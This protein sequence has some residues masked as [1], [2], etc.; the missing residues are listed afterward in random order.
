MKQLFLPS[1]YFTINEQ[2]V[3][4][5]ERSPLKMYIS[6]I[7]K[8]IKLC[9]T[10]MQKMFYVLQA[11]VCAGQKLTHSIH[12]TNINL[13][14]DYWFMSIDTTQKFFKKNVAGRKNRTKNP[15]SFLNTKAR[16]TNSDLFSYSGPL[17]L[18]L[19]GSPKSK[20]KIVLMVSTKYKI[21]DEPNSVNLPSI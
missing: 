5:R 10:V 6:S 15:P 13:T 14:M 20:K 16:K 9:C 12:R 7:S 2:L 1:R 21:G 3:D 18:L 19:F 4:F 8:G 11:E 17:K